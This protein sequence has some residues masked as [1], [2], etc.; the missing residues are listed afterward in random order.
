[1]SVLLTWLKRRRRGGRQLS[2]GGTR[3]CQST[4][5]GVRRAGLE[6]G[7]SSL[8]ATLNHWACVSPPAVLPAPTPTLIAS[9]PP[10]CPTLPRSCDATC[11]R[12]Q[13]PPP[14]FQARVLP[15]LL[16]PHTYSGASYPWWSYS[17]FLTGWIPNRRKMG[18]S[19][20]QREWKQSCTEQPA[21]TWRSDHHPEKRARP[22]DSVP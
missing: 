4:S 16:A 1:M 12:C 18:E 22:R 21:L 11:L 17:L 7:P 2:S 6:E 15:W 9:A 8:S 20:C 5:R 19:D 13:R 3:W 14:S 10:S